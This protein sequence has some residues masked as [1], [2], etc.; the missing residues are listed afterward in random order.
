LKNGNANP[1]ID[2]EGYKDY[3]ADREQAFYAALKKQQ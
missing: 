1:F 3:V 2:P